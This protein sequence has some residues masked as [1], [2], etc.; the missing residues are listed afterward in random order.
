MRL[1]TFVAENMQDAMNQV[2]HEMGDDA[3]IISTQRNSKGKGI[4]V[5]AAKDDGIA[6]DDGFAIRDPEIQAQQAPD[7]E[8]QTLLPDY[9]VR[10][11]EQILHHH[12]TV[13]ETTEAIL[14]QVRRLPYPDDD[15]DTSL[16]SLLEQAL[17]ATLR[18]DTLPLMAPGIRYILIG[19]PGSGKTLTTAKLVAR[20]VKSGESVRVVTTD[21]K[22]AGA[23]EQLMAYT[24][25]LG[26][27]L[28]IAQDRSELKQIVRSLDEK[29]RLIVDTAGASPYNFYELKDLAEFA[30]LIE[31]EPLLV[32]PAGSDP[33]EATEI[34]EAFSFI[35][36]ERMM[37]TRMDVTKRYGGILTAAHASG[38]SLTLAAAGE[39]VLDEM[40]IFTPSYLAQILMDYRK[41]GK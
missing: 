13:T 3:V 39:S 2:R 1:R 9:I 37:A 10:D 36:V 12:G 25:V 38:F 5:T 16:H 24:D 15:S 19:M 31:L 23:I 17:K 22:R 18:F 28:E 14:E 27:E 26:I 29:E 34:A 32:Y 41:K 6:D 8:V 11:I 4:S 30:G 7:T 40:I 35:G 21:M 20:I 33:L